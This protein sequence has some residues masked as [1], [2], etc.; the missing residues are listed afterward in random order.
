MGEKNHNFAHFR[1]AS[2]NIN[3]F[4]ICEIFILLLECKLVR[5]KSYQ[6]PASHPVKT[7]TLRLKSHTFHC[8]HWKHL[9]GC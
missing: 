9:Q 1:K 4:I 2:V 8:L 3:L 7:A 5:S 6:P